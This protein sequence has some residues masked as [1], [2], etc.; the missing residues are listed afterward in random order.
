MYLDDPYT[1]GCRLRVRTPAKEE[2]DVYSFPDDDPYM[3]EVC[4]FIEAIR[5]KNAKQ[6]E[7]SYSDA[8]KTYSLT[9]AIRNAESKK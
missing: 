6:I 1:S 3:T 8:A 5:T 7:S 9:W 2:E 4:D